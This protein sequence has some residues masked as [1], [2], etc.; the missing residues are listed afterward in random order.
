MQVVALAYPAT[1]S[2]AVTHDPTPSVANPG[3]TIPPVPREDHLGGLSAGAIA[4]MVGG[5]CGALWIAAIAW[6]LIRDQRKNK[7]MQQ[8]VR[9]RV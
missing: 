5:I 1:M 3:F 8:A 6:M 9:A 4:G 2:A 7:K